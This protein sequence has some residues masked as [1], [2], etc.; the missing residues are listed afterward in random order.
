MLQIYQ[1]K[2]NAVPKT[3][4]QHLINYLSEITLPFPQQLQQLQFLQLQ[5]P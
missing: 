1:K 5:L 3:S 4:E 2:Q